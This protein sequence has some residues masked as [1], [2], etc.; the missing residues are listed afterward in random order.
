LLEEQPVEELLVIVEP[1]PVVEEP[2]VIENL[3]ELL[4]VV[5]QFRR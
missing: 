4:L 3:Q 2:E 1:E 5:I